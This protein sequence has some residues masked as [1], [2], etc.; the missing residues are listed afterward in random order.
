MCLECGRQK[1][2][3]GVEARGALSLAVSVG[4]LECIIQCAYGRPRESFMRPS[5]SAVDP[6]LLAN[7]A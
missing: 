5:L 1:R 7:D 3:S 6:Q 4:C 2:R